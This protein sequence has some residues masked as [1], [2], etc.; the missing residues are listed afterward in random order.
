MALIRGYEGCYK[1]PGECRHLMAAYVEV[2]STA[3]GPDGSFQ[4]MASEVIQGLRA[5]QQAQLL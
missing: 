1:W 5:T 4:L 3:A 2:D